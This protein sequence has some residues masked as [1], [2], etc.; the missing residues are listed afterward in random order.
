MM[1]KW[2]GLGGGGY[3]LIGLS[4]TTCCKERKLSGF[5]VP[6]LRFALDGIFDSFQDLAPRLP[7]KPSEPR[8]R[9][10]SSVVGSGS[11]DSGANDSL[12][13]AQDLSLSKVAVSNNRK[14]YPPSFSPRFFPY[15]WHALRPSSVL[16]I[17][18]FR[19]SAPRST[20]SILNTYRMVSA[21]M[22]PDSPLWV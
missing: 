4:L 15:S 8:P 3:A 19:E 7:F 18:C 9:T 20:M 5:S 16:T 21:I 1:K 14:R 11:N 22:G 17:S 12:R 2:S 10:G 6:R 13:Q